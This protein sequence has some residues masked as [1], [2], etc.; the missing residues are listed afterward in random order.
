MAKIIYVDNNGSQ[1]VLRESTD[2]IEGDVL[3]RSDYIAAKLWSDDEIASALA[4]NGYAPTMMN[5]NTIKNSGLLKGLEE[6]SDGDWQIIKDAVMANAEDGDIYKLTSSVEELCLVHERVV[7][8]C[9]DGD[10]SEYMFIAPDDKT[11]IDSIDIGACIEDT[12]HRLIE[13]GATENAIRRELGAVQ[14]TDDMQDDLIVS[15]DLG[16]VLPGLIL[17]AW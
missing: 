14:M 13:N 3:F 16:Y 1:K 9:I 17:N 8:F 2:L 12:L 7:H 6:A 11:G 4:E 10:Y 5:V 15:I